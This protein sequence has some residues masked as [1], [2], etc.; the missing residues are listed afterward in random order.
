MGGYLFTSFSVSAVHVTLTAVSFI[1]VTVMSET[2]TLGAAERS[3]KY[4]IR[5]YIWLEL[6]IVHIILYVH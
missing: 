1:L 6:Q 2:G 4:Y 5:R 3:K